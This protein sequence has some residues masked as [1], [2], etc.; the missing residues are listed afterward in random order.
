MKGLVDSVPV[1]LVTK[2]DLGLLGAFV[3]FITF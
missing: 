2:D 1:Y 3:I